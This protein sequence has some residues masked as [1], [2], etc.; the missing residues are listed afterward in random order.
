MRFAWVATEKATH[1]L[2]VLCRVLR[3]TPSGFYAWQRRPLSAHARRDGELD[4]RIRALFTKARQRYGSPR[5]HDDLREAGV[6]VS[7]K[8][9]A[10]LMRQAGLRARQ[11]KRYRS[12]TMRCARPADRAQSPRAGVRGPRAQLALGG[13]HDR[14]CH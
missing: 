5:I 7:R 12:T 9:V 14:V 4:V 8:R 2:R 1:P 6:P 3:V 10:R 11:R 13:R